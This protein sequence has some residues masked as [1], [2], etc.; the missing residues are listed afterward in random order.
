[1]DPR[2]P[3]SRQRTKFP[4]ELVKQMKSVFVEGFKGQLGKAVVE[5][6]GR[7]YPGE[8]MLSLG[9]RRANQLKQPNF[10]ISLAYDAKKENV[11]KLFHTM[12]DAMGALFDQYF[13]SDDD[14]EF[15]RYWEE[16]DFEG[17]KLFVQYATDNS[18]LEKKANKLLGLEENEELIRNDKS[19]EELEDIK[20][21][22]GLD[23]DED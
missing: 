15:P 6:D 3:T 20:Q 7:I 13:Q 9:F 1:M 10:Q 2:L 23:D 14:S 17:K 11:L 21:K 22:L 12:I 18:K 8:L 4:D 16:L 5:I 19:Q